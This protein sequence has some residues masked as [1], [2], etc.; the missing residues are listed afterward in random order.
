MMVDD[1]LA[2]HTNTR[3]EL[4]KMKAELKILLSSIVNNQQLLP[5]TEVKLNDCLIPSSFRGERIEDLRSQLKYEEKNFAL[6]RR[7]LL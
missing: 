2:I 5:S 1:K 6:T 7:K 3:L 4:E